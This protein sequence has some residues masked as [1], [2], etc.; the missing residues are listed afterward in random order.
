MDLL[1]ANLPIRRSANSGFALLA[2]LWLVTALTLVAGVGITVARTG[3][4]TTRNRVLLARAEW[5]REACGEIL[6]ARYAD[7]HQV[8][9]IDSVDLGRGTWCRVVIEDPSARVD[10]NTASQDVL[11]R[12]LA[13]VGSQSWVVDS[14]LAIRKRGTIDDLGQIGIDSALAARLIPFVTA[15]GTGVIN[16]NSAPRVVLGVLPGITEEAMEVV[17][18]R[19]TIGRPLEGVDALAVLLSKSGRATLYGEYAE[20]VHQATFAPSQLIALVEGGVGGTALRARATL[21]LVVVGE[22]L[23]VIRREEE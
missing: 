1:S 9:A 13:V 12:L 5:S 16:V 17:L 4:Q 8:R 7:Q 10:L 21:T 6:L 11:E 3:S 22:R 23:A 19:R 15:R 18:A 2:V 20:F 14:I